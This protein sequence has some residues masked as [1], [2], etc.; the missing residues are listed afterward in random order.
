[1]VTHSPQG[2]PVACY[3]PDFLVL[4]VHPRSENTGPYKNTCTDVQRA[5]KAVAKV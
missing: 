3:D 1:M 2:P 4:D 5:F